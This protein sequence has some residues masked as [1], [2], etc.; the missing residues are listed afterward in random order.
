METAFPQRIALCMR[1]SRLTVDGVRCLHGKEAPRM[2]SVRCTDV[3]A[4]PT[5]YLDV[6]SVTRDA[7][8]Q[9]VPPGEAVCQAPLAV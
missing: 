8:Q 4:R 9:R 1:L 6:T 5:E 7:F 2:T 3:Q